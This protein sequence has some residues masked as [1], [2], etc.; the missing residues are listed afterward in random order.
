MKNTF[1]AFL[2]SWFAFS[3][4]N[5]QSYYL[6]AK[7][8][9]AVGQQRWNDQS[10]AQNSLLFA[11]HGDLFYESAPEDATSVSFAQVGY[12]VRGSAFRFRSGV[13]VD[14]NG[15]PIEYKGFTQRFEFNN[16]AL[17]L[18]VKKRGVLGRERAYY[19]VG[20]RGEY[21]VSTNL[22][23]GSTGGAYAAIYPTQ[24]FV[25]KFNGGLSL[26]GGYEMPFSD[27]TGAFIEVGVHP[28]V[29]RQYFQPPI[30]GLNW[31]DPFSGTTIGSVPQRSIRNLSFEVTLGFRFLRKIIYTD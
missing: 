2:L 20:L 25:R 22:G 8:G 23:D 5:A 28:D 11:Y 9:L 4:L 16:I 17:V 26:F 1:F 27:L 3:N 30:T 7:G 19:A 18:G 31:R 21:T 13:G 6:G 15:Q 14:V 24:N 29:T 12:H 10:S